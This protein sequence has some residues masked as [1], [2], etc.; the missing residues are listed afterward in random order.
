MVSKMTNDKGVIAVICVL[1]VTFA[2][3]IIYTCY[4]DHCQNVTHPMLS[5][6][7]LR[8]LAGCCIGFLA[9]MNYHNSGEKVFTLLFTAMAL[10]YNPVFPVYDIMGTESALHIGM[11]EIWWIAF[12]VMVLLSCWLWLC[13]SHHHNTPP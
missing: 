13:T 4:S 12:D 11:I 5:E 8:W 3:G 2:L 1:L 9:Y 6:H 7:L 10:M